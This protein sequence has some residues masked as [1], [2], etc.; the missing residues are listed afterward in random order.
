LPANLLHLLKLWSKIVPA[1]VSG[2][3]EFVRHFFMESAQ[4]LEEWAKLAAIIAHDRFDLRFLCIRQLKA[5]Q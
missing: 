1:D 3:Q 4:L 2:R 5:T